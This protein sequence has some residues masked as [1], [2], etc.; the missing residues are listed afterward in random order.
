[1]PFLISLG[2]YA[3]LAGVIGFLMPRR[4]FCGNTRRLGALVVTGGLVLMG[5]GGNL[6]GSRWTGAVMINPY[7]HAGVSGLP[8]AEAKPAV[9]HSRTTSP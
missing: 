3:L 5:I 8:G 4:F 2:F 7:I 6:V 9:R 1:M